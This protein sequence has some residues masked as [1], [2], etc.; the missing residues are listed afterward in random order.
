MKKILLLLAITA[1][2]GFGLDE[3]MVKVKITDEIDCLLPQSFY[4]MGDGDITRRMPASKKPMV[5]YSD[6]SQLV[7]FVVTRATVSWEK[8]DINIAK[9][10]YKANISHLYDEVEFTKEE[11]ITIDKRQFAVFEFN[12][13]MKGDQLSKKNIRKYA[14]LQYTIVDHQTIVFAFNAPYHLRGK[15]SATAKNIMNSLK[16]K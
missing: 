5:A 15:W 9:D 6:Q 16:I 13:L 3:K 12:S 11:V 4:L 14:Y 10:F 8:E 2:C 1:I 7:D